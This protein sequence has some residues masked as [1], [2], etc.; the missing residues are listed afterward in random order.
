[1]TVAP[2]FLAGRS[3]LVLGAG[4]FIGLHLCQAL[5]AAG[6]QVHG[7]GHPPAFP[8]ALPPIRWTTGEFH[9]VAALA[10]A[11]RGAEVV[12]HLLGGSIPDIS[13]RD[14]QADLQGN[15]LASI[16][17]LELCRDAGVRKLVFISSGGTVY[18]VPRVIPIPES[19]PT[20]PI[21]AYG[22]HK[23]MVEKYLGLHAHLHGLRSVVLRAANP[24]GPYQGPNRGQGVVAA[25]I[26]TRLA[27]RPVEIWGDGRVVR[28]FL[29]VGDL[30]EAML[31]AALYEGP[32]RVLNVGSGLGRS[33]LDV[34]A[35]VGA[36]LGLGPAEILFKPGRKA[37]VP[38][39]VLDT[40][41]I[42][43]ELGWEPR[44]GWERGLRLTADW[45]AA[46]YPR[47]G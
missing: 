34:V 32:Q 10:E 13:N 25:L 8:E 33:V 39:N 16:R 36:T 4:G 20:D 5:V 14:P 9:D 43:R 24:F 12:F 28:D 41:L 40:T 7:F 27:G 23:L 1:V 18:G 45:I 26:A 47:R 35:A 6:A 44:M 22:I 21:S 15:L 31:R 17:L 3:C 37:D 2:D 30:A 38:E 19:H 42:R 29:Y 46:T 11:L